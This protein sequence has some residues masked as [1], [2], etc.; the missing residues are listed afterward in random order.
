MMLWEADS[1]YA[2]MALHPASE[3]VPPSV[4]F[5]PTIRALFENEEVHAADTLDDQHQLIVILTL[6]R[7]LWSVKEFEASPVN[8]LVRQSHV[9]S[10]SKKHVQEVL[11][12]FLLGTHSKSRL[13]TKKA[14][15][16]FVHR[17]QIVHMSYLYGAGNLMD[18]IHPLLRGGQQANSAKISMAHWGSHDAVRLRSVAYHSSQILALIRLF[19]NNEPL[20]AFNVFHAGV[21]LWCTAGMLGKTRVAEKQSRVGS[22]AYRIDSTAKELGTESEDDT[23]W[24]KS[25]EP[26]IVSLDGVPDLCCRDGQVQVLEIIAEMLDRMRVWGVAKNF[27]LV[28]LQL[29][30]REAK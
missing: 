12:K 29:L 30:Q 15:A 8:D 27:L 18:W 13:R 7:I 6:T 5:K 23:A 4:A 20:E 26:S 14:L 10:E 16:A 1:S 2:W 24:I 3:S 9:L 11:H 19:P 25:G 17:T 21:V 22:T 28:V